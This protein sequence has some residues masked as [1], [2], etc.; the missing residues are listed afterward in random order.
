MTQSATSSRSAPATQDDPDIASGRHRTVP[1]AHPE[2][3]ISPDQWCW[4]W[5]C[6]GRGWNSVERIQTA[7]LDPLVDLRLLYQR[8]LE[9]ACLEL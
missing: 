4:C 5:C 2:M 8:G 1:G 6:G 3:G 7:N 9:I